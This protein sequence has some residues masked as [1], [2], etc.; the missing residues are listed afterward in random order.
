MA[1]KI[2][3]DL[4]GDVIKKSK[5]KAEKTKDSLDKKVTRH[6]KADAQQDFFPETIPTTAE[7]KKALTA[8]QKKKLK[9]SQMDMFPKELKDAKKKINKKAGGGKIE[10]A[11]NIAKKGVEKG[12]EYLKK[13]KQKKSADK[14][15]ELLESRAYTKDA[16]GNVTKV[17]HKDSPKPAPPKKTKANLSL[18]EKLA[19]K[20]QRRKRQANLATIPGG[21]MSTR[22]R[23][24]VLKRMA[25]SGY[26]GGGKIDKRALKETIKDIPRVAKEQAKKV[27]S[28]L[29]KGSS[30]A[31]PP[32]R[33]RKRTPKVI[34]A[35]GGGVVKKYASGGP[36]KKSIDGIAQRGL[37]R[38]KHK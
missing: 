31:G 25:Q 2:L 15:K 21:K 7:G 3:K 19:A 22:E 18:K 26:A 17:T 4:L 33:N 32:P 5:G 13:R 1:K 38:A 20:K 9:E 35:K 30:V 14:K 28:Y 23:N 16:E 27:G 8:A 10:L 12:K 29:R 11:K 6:T 24:K 34:K 37:T 36:V